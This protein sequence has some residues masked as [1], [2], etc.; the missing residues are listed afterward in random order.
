MK[1]IGLAGFGVVGKH[2]Y[3]QIQSDFAGYF[4]VEK[5]AIKNR[6]KHPE[7][8]IPFTENVF[9]LAYSSEIDIVI[10][11]IG[12]IQPAFDFIKECLKNKKHVITANK[13]LMA[14]HGDELRLLASKNNVQLRYEAS[15][16]GA[17]PILETL[18]TNLRHHKITGISGIMNG[19]TNFI[20]TQLSERLNASVS[21]ILKTAREL[22]FLEADPSFDLEGWDI[23]QKLSIVIYQAFGLSIEP[24]QIPCF[25]LMNISDDE[26]VLNRFGRLKY[27]ASV[28]KTNDEIQAMVMPELV[29]TSH[30]F[31]SISNENNAVEVVT[32]YSGTH[33]LSGKGAGG[34]PT[35]ASVIVDL[36]AICHSSNNSMNL[37]Q[38]VRADNH[39]QHVIL[40]Q[41]YVRVKPE[42]VFAFNKQLSSLSIVAKWITDTQLI[43]KKVSVSDLNQLKS[44]V[45]IF[46][47][48]PKD[49]YI[50]KHSLPTYLVTAAV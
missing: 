1:K 21:D 30:S 24:A 50:S 22:G 11:V 9:D 15:V 32:K 39:V 40:D 12:G 33:I 10:E 43:L 31:Y 13:Y 41:V 35:A 42:S 49:I 16:G 29:E 38:S 26:R 2:V 17:I 7:K 48:I 34:N 3:Q 25:S 46:I 45:D 18:T 20:L 23:Q 37:T 4:S 44:F 47:K 8:N 5:V 6:S 14:Y 27:V 36:I 28:H 19:S